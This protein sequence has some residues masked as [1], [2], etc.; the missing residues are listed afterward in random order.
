MLFEYE[1]V[2][3]DLTNSPF[4]IYAHILLVMAIHIICNKIINYILIK[5]FSVNRYIAPCFFKLF[6]VNFDIILLKIY[7]V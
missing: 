7:V 4:C 3:R 2:L 5:Q 6:S 1:H